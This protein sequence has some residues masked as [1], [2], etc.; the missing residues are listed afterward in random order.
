MDQR[1]QN[2]LAKLSQMPP[3]VRTQ[4]LQTMPPELKA[5]LQQGGGMPPPGAPTPPMAPPQGNN[6]YD[7][8]IPQPRP[9]MPPR[10]M[11][12]PRPQMPQPRPQMPQPGPQ[13]GGGMPP[14]PPQ[15]Q[16]PQGPPPQRP[17][18]PPPGRGQLQGQPP[19]APGNRMNQRL[20]QQPQQPSLAQLFN[21]RQY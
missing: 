21:Q 3:E 14:Q 11:P 16:R 8:A 2:I 13:V 17:M 1:M 5:Q 9:Q 10:Q 15:Q 18:T 7:K 19:A 12:Q 6:P 20:A 4:I